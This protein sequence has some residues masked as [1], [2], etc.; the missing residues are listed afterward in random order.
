MSV[1]SIQ[2]KKSL[3]EF[4]FTYYNYMNNI[5]SRL[6]TLFL[7]YLKQQTHYSKL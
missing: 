4:S 7:N 2:R 6:D 5:Q 3:L 1:T